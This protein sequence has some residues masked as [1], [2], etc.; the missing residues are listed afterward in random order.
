MNSGR[1][2]VGVGEEVDVDI[3]KGLGVNVDVGDGARVN[4]GDNEGIEIG[5][6]DGVNTGALGDMSAVDGEGAPQV[7]SS[8]ATICSSF[9]VSFTMSAQLPTINK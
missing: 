3:G 6:V 7:T 9:P 2:S 4:V 5:V 8:L 1:G